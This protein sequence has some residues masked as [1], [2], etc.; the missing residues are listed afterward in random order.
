[1]R[2][3]KYVRPGFSNGTNWEATVE[4]ERNTANLRWMSGTV[5]VTEGPPARTQE[6]S[7][8]QH[9]LTRQ[10]AM[11]GSGNRCP[12]C[13]SIIYSR[14][15]KLCGVCTEE[16]PAELLFPRQ[17][18]QRLQCLMRSEELRHR[19]WMAKALHQALAPSFLP[20]PLR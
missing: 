8:A 2:I 19:T 6:A 9:G 10:L 18:A 12:H 3:M 4:S 7:P 20:G 5:P 14:R 15:H 16:L 11:P 13:G 17:E 1:M